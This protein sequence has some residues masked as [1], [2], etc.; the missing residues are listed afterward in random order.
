MIFLS[1][2]ELI[3]RVFNSISENELV[4]LAKYIGVKVSGFREISN[5]VPQA[6]LIN[7]IKL[8]LLKKNVEPICNKESYIKLYDE[9]KN[10]FFVHILSDLNFKRNE[11]LV[12]SV[13]DDLFKATIMDSNKNI[14]YCNIELLKNENE[15]L[16]KQN[17]YLSDEIKKLKREHRK[18][19][20]I[21]TK[22]Y[23][24]YLKN[25]KEKL[26]EQKKLENDIQLIRNKNV[27]IIDD[28]AKLKR[29][30]LE[31]EEKIEIMQYMKKFFSIKHLLLLNMQP[32]D[33]NF[34][35]K[36]NIITIDE[37]LR[38]KLPKERITDLWII[39]NC[40]NDFVLTQVIT[41]LCKEYP[42]INITYLEDREI[43]YLGVGVLNE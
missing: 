41:I 35:Y 25:E 16:K 8:K 39:K 40:E 4:D 5:L 11:I 15:R 17:E 3:S 7:G 27:N 2:D 43:K 31:Y 6:L 21:L 22:Q 36:Y 24:E 14:D 28:N 29:T 20:D 33:T 19:I 30:I 13:I 12:K 32:I 18:E 10:K 23:T 26:K 38:L 1:N 42:D 34:P 37:I 9:N